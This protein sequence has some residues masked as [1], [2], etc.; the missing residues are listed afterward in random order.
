MNTVFSVSVIKKC[1][2]MFSLLAKFL[3]AVEWMDVVQNH[4]V[5]K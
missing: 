5:H 2:I 4:Q 1:N 3:D